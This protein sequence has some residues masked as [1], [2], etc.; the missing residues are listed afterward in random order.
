M[1]L[2][3]S[4]SSRAGL[5]TQCLVDALRIRRIPA[6]ARYRRALQRANFALLARQL[7][8]PR[9]ARVRILGYTIRSQTLET[10]AFLFREVFV[11]RDYFFQTSVP[12][13]FIIDAGGNVGMATVYFKTLYPDATIL[14]F[15]PGP[16]AFRMLQE[17]IRAN[18]LTKVQAL[19][20]ALGARE[21]TIDFYVDPDRPDSLLMS[22]LPRR[23]A[24]ASHRVGMVRL[25]T[26][27]DREVDF[28]KI[29]VEGAEEAVL[30]EL[31]EADKLGLVRQMV[32]EYHH[33]IEP[34]RDALAGMLRLLE[35]AGFGYQLTTR[36]DVGLRAS[37]GREF[38]DVLIYAYRKST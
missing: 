7:F 34:E 23:M 28:L 31:A 25:S 30:G 12:A 18:G 20:H 9:S 24:K 13:P 5:V 2:A 15:E 17:N 6:S 27:I 3:E 37:G 16:Q 22:T 10:L 21:G 26:F 29:D 11:R 14:A 19:P 1:S 4:Q 32:V 33:H 36:A 8:S 35:Q 38:Q